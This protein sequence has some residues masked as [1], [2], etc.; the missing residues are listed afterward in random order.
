MSEYAGQDPDDELLP[1]QSTDDTDSGWG[2]RPH[3]SDDDE[4]LTREVPPHY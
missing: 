3:E 1:E 4:R 2:E